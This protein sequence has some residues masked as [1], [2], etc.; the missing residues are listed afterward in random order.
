MLTGAALYYRHITLNDFPGSDDL[1]PRTISGLA[2]TQ[3]FSGQEAVDSIQQLHGQEFEIEDGAVAVY[4]NQNVILWVSDAG[5]LDVAGELTN[6]MKDRISEGRSP[7]TALGSFDVEGSEIFEL[8]GMGQ[9][10]FYWQSGNQVI[11]LS[12]DEHLAGPALQESVEYFR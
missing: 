7:F 1:V 8:E 11:W 3:F 6:Q 5:S 10:H 2:L 4:G 9:S 12:T